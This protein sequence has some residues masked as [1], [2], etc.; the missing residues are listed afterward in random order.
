MPP[1][2]PLLT[3][4]AAHTLARPESV[5][6]TNAKPSKADLPKESNASMMSA[7][8]LN[9]KLLNRPKSSCYGQ[10]LNSH[11]RQKSTL[12]MPGL[13]IANDELMLLCEAKIKKDKELANAAAA[14]KV[15]LTTA[16]SQRATPQNLA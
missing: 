3:I 13:S 6:S 12:M 11:N 16:V 9:R 5:K 15:T 2:S 14:D 1:A 8:S 7:P 4:K 10:Q